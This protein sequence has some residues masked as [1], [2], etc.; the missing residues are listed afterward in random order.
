MVE[1]LPGDKSAGEHIDILEQFPQGKASAR[2]LAKVRSFVKTGAK[3]RAAD[4]KKGLIR[5]RKRLEAM[6]IA[7]SAVVPRLPEG[8][9]LDA[10]FNAALERFKRE[11]LAASE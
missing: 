11:L 2:L 7:G 10:E 8:A 3:T 9:D 6:G 4:R 5:E 1:A